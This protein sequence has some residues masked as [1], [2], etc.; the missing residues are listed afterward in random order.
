[1]ACDECDRLR[2][3]LREVKEELAEYASAPSSEA[4][5]GETARLGRWM[6]ALR[7]THGQARLIMAFAESPGRVFSRDDLTDRL[8]GIGWANCLDRAIDS[9]MKHLRRVLRVAL[10]T[11]HDPIRTLYGV[12]YLM[13]APT[14][15]SVRALVGE[16][17]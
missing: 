15:A 1:M 7:C 9:R 14:A 8:R 4:D 5:Y 13:E 11:E 17:A 3:E 10:A 6:T 2:R 12:G 16:P